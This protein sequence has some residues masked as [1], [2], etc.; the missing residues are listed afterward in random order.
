MKLALV[1]PELP[2]SDVAP[3]FNLALLASC[4]RLAF[5]DVEVRIFDGSVE[6]CVGESIVAWGPDLVGVTAMTP[7]AS[8]AYRLIHYLRKNEIKT[9]LG[10]VHATAFPLEALEHADIVVTGEGEITL[11]EIINELREGKD[12]HGIY[13][14][15]EVSNLDDLPFPAF[16]LI[17][18]QAYVNRSGYVP[19]LDQYPQVRLVTSRGCPFTCRFCTNSKR[20]SAV[21]Y[22]SAAYIYNM[23][24]VLVTDYG[25]KAIW[26]YDDE[27]IANKERII[28]FT[29]RMIY[30]FGGQLPWACQAR[31]TSIKPHVAM[32]LKAA[33]C[34]CV[35]FGI[36]SADPKVLEYL[37]RGSVTIKQVEDAIDTCKKAGLAVMGSFIFGSPNDTAASLDRTITWVNSMRHR[38]L[39]IAGFSLLAPYPQTE[40][41]DRFYEGDNPPMINDQL[42]DY[43]RLIA[44]KDVTVAYSLGVMAKR[45]MAKYVRKASLLFYVGDVVAMRRYRGLYTRTFVRALLAYPREVTKL[46]WGK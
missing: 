25:I 23:V 10:G 17:N 15:V 16:D 12:P 31:A 6:L 34:K 30:S 22:H 5:C 28:D 33:G 45:E 11:V 19:P 35:L 38:G 46:L 8:A 26:F 44:T 18:W 7:Q 3:P 27:F 42:L 41:W 2:L 4:V 32:L 20:K 37:K 29:Q 43:D 13:E 36:E 14:G 21:R 9:I 1:V 24:Q 39:S 40:I